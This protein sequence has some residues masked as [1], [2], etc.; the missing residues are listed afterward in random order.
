MIDEFW[1]ERDHVSSNLVWDVIQTHLFMWVS[2]K[3]QQS[4][5]MG[6]FYDM[7]GK[8]TEWSVPNNCN[9]ALPLWW[10][11]IQLYKASY[12]KLSDLDGLKRTK[13]FWEPG[14][15]N[16]GASLK[17]T[18]RCLQWRMIIYHMV[19]IKTPSILQHLTYVRRITSPSIPKTKG[20]S[21]RVFVLQQHP[22]NTTRCW[23]HNCNDFIVDITYRWH[24]E[25]FFSILWNIG[26]CRT[27]LR[28]LQ[29]IKVHR[30]HLKWLKNMFKSSGPCSDVPMVFHLYTLQIFCSQ[31][32]ICSLVSTIMFFVQLK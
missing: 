18:G 3:L 29:V 14:S 2:H 12:Q 31:C 6:V 21:H 28:F 19:G 27:M 13:L 16:S 9:G 7:A 8:T 23:G 32:P 10:H 25:D 17:K 4:K 30:G 26:M 1:N 11:V 15:R 5:P 22:G 20:C 24:M